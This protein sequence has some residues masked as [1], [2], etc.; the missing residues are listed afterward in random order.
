[1]ILDTTWS[2]AAGKCSICR[3]EEY[4]CLD[5][6]LHV[7]D[8]LITQSGIPPCYLY[9][10]ILYKYIANNFFLKCNK[11][12]EWPKRKKQANKMGMVVRL[13]SPHKL[14]MHIHDVVRLYNYT[15]LCAWH[16]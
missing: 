2:S 8:S 3:A 7:N 1:M 10:S 12:Q 5:H 16:L 11:T 9:D 13:C 15:F 4:I 6:S 14:I